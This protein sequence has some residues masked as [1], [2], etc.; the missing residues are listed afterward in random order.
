MQR[1]AGRRSLLSL[2]CLWVVTS[3]ISPGRQTCLAKFH[4]LELEG[5]AEISGSNPFFLLVRLLRVRRE[6]GC[7]R[8]QSTVII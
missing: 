8:S 5:A 4:A 1:A 3:Q 2:F 7:P 6:G